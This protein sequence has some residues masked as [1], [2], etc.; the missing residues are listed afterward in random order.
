MKN[1]RNMNKRWW[2]TKSSIIEYI[3]F[4]GLIISATLAMYSHFKGSPA[5]VFFN[6][7]IIFVVS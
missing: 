4:A 5:M 6:L 7:C 3:G 2:L 1:N